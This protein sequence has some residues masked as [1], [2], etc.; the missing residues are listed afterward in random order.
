MKNLSFV[1]N[2]EAAN[3]PEWHKEIMDQRMENYRIVVDLLQAKT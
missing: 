2:I 1:E 3:I